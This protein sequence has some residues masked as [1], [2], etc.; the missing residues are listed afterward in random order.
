VGGWWVEESG[1]V[2]VE[3][4]ITDVARAKHVVASR[5]TCEEGAT[6]KVESKLNELAHAFRLSF[7]F[8][9]C[10]SIDGRG[11]LTLHVVGYLGKVACTD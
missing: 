5:H 9:P 1:S 2:C 4:F 8:Y 7:L 6:G 11:L 3:S 10:E